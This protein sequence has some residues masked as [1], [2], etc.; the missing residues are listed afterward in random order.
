M[1]RRSRSTGRSPSLVSA[2]TMAEMEKELR[3][4]VESRDEIF[5]EARDLR[6]RSQS[7]MR[8]IHAGDRLLREYEALP[9]IARRLVERARPA[10]LLEEEPVQTA[11][12]E[13]VEASLLRAVVMGRSLPTPPSLFVGAVPYLLGLSDLVGE[14]RRLAVT[15]LGKGAPERAEAQVRQ[16]DDILAILMHF[17]AP[18][19]VI[20][21]KPKQDTARSLLE[22]TRGEVAMA[23]YLQSI[24]RKGGSKGPEKRR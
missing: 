12:Q 2:Q 9:G 16:M 22:K 20:A 18:R 21:L 11:L 19:S 7:V 17:E 10:R 23:L 4:L 24:V 14:L 1:T 6:R 3:E 8:R 5:E 15:S 13:W